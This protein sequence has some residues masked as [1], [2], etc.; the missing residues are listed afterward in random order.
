MLVLRAWQVLTHSG[1]SELERY[2]GRTLWPTEELEVIGLLIEGAARGRNIWKHAGNNGYG[3]LISELLP[4]LRPAMLTPNDLRRLT[5]LIRFIPP[6]PLSSVCRLQLNLQFG[7]P[8]FDATRGAADIVILW[9][10]RNGRSFGNNCAVM[11][12]HSEPQR[13]DRPPAY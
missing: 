7:P 5:I 1:D 13:T 8:P 9:P 6:Q 3:S 12:A 4:S 11:R 2:K 10:C